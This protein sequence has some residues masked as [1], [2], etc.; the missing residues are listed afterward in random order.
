MEV[1]KKYN[2]VKGML[3]Y[4][5]FG[6]SFFAGLTI[7]G[8]RKN[9]VSN[10]NQ[11]TSNNIVD[12]N[13]FESIEISP[14]NLQQMIWDVKKQNHW[15][16]IS[17]LIVIESVDAYNEKD[18]YILEQYNHNSLGVYYHEYRWLFYACY[19]TIEGKNCWVNADKVCVNEFQPLFNYLTEEEMQ[20]IT[21]NDGQI[22]T[23]ELDQILTRIRQE[24][25]IQQEQNNFS[26]TLE[27]N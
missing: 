20:E 13:L 10:N 16:D 11:V 22:S 23:F 19:P 15:F 14:I 7:G 12:E 3:I 27:N 2:K 1:Q 8:S 24:Y 17:D 25:K 18:L 5:G 6:L 4:L 9:T 26:R 21:R